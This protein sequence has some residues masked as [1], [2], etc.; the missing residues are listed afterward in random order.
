MRVS[1]MH[2]RLGDRAEVGIAQLSRLQHL[3]VAI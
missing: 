2:L 1:G 3:A